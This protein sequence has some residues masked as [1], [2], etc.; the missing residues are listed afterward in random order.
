MPYIWPSVS[1]SINLD[2]DDIED[3]EQEIKQ[4]VLEDLVKMVYRTTP[5]PVVGAETME[6]LTA[7]GSAVDRYRRN[8]LHEMGQS[9]K[10][11]SK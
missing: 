1:Q 9:I 7:F 11:E 8:I 10:N 6:P 3:R 2:L 5:M 4:M